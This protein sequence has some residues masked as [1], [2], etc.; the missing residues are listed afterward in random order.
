M[1][2]TPENGVV[3]ESEVRISNLADKFI[4]FSGLVMSYLLES[5]TI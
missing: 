3:D 5:F 1:Q 4:L 2:P